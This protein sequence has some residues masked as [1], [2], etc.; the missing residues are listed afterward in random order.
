[1]TM[2][3][4]KDIDIMRLTQENADLKVRV[5]EMNAQAQ[6]V[7]WKGNTSHRILLAGDSTIRDVD[8]EK[9]KETEV[10][11]M[12]GAKVTKPDMK[13]IIKRYADDNKKYDEVILVIGT[14]DCEEAKNEAEIQKAVEDYTSIIQQTKAITKKVTVSGVCPRLDSAQENVNIMNASLQGV[15]QQLSC[16]FI[17]NNP[18]FILS[19]GS[20]NDGYI[21]GDGPHLTRS[22]TN[23]LIKNLAIP[24]KENVKDVTKPFRP[25]STNRKGQG[26][27]QTHIQSNNQ[28]YTAEFWSVARQ[29]ATGTRYPQDHNQ[30]TATHQNHT[31]Y[32]SSHSYENRANHSPCWFCGLSGHISRNC[33]FGE[34]V[35]CLSC[36]EKGHKEKVCPYEGY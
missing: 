7:T 19:D 31:S 26:H 34:P 16:N 24:K 33:H 6:Q 28:D 14:N 13:D 5:G 3:Q 12:S 30:K 18:S 17:D 9:L 36:G 27:Q 25:R 4:N 2:L 23:K 15:C 8:E 11:C 29:K 10:I 32:P 35:T 21:I 20:V 1:M 22:G